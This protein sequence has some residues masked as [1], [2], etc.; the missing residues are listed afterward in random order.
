MQNNSDRE[1][2]LE[3][4]FA[5]LDGA[6]EKLGAEDVSLEDAFKAYSEGMEILKTCNAQIERVEKQVQLLNEAGELEAL[7]DGNE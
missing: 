2:T 1:Y 5:R 3:E 6:L 4:N 7:D